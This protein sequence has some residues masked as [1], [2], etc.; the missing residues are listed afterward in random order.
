MYK[1]RGTIK[2]SLMGISIAWG[3]FALLLLFS[4]F[5]FEAG[6]KNC[7]YCN[8][9]MWILLL[10]LCL[11]GL[12]VAAILLTSSVVLNDVCFALDKMSL[13]NF[14]DLGFID[15][16]FKA[17]IKD[18]SQDGSGD[19]LKILGVDLGNDLT[20]LI[21]Q[22]SIPADIINSMQLLGATALTLPQHNQIMK[23]YT[24]YY[25][26]YSNLEIIYG[27]S[28]STLIINAG[29]EL[30]AAFNPT[31]VAFQQSQCPISSS[32]VNT[33]TA[34]KSA[35]CCVL[36]DETLPLDASYSGT[37]LE[38]LYNFTRDLYEIITQSANSLDK[39]LIS[40]NINSVAS[41]AVDINPIISNIA[42]IQD[43]LSTLS[44]ALSA[45]INGLNCSILGKDIKYLVYG[46]CGN[47]MRSVSGYSVVLVVASV[48]TSLIVV[49][50]AIFNKC[51]THEF[52]EQDL[53]KTA[54]MPTES[55][56]DVSLRNITLIKKQKNVA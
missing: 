29:S 8:Y 17:I 49:F 21:N 26:L 45:G 24:D 43:K 55:S 15:E 13:N 16:Q 30:S 54:P 48:S 41:I 33:S 4:M 28:L 23:Q 50:T 47:L 40:P 20:E 38:Y 9:F 36:I 46:V 12:P 3:A 25:N 18:C 31:T 51:F 14:K 32:V 52:S 56:L 39:S 37:K 44:S 11:C 10:V 34:L 5:I 35:D 7:K 27:S 19:L 1:S 42:I 6:L 2:N 53:K 22:A